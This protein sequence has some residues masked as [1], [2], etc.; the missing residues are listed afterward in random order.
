MPLLDIFLM[1]LYIFLFVAYLIILFQI[2][3]DLFRDKGTNGWVKAIWVVAL[4]FIPFLTALIYLIVRG[5]GMAERRAEDLQAMHEAQVEYT[6]SLITEA[7]GTANAGGGSNTAE[8]L[9]HAKDLL[10]S[11]AL[12][13]EEFDALKAKALA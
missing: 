11:G 4:L 2:L 5:Q 10:D 7:G 13:Q 9:K 6:R 3:S 8:Q 12:T 1:T